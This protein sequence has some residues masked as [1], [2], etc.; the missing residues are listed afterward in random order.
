MQPP[1]QV[2]FLH[3]SLPPASTIHILLWRHIIW[4][5]GLVWTLGIYQ[6]VMCGG[7]ADIRDL[8]CFWCDAWVIANQSCHCP[9]Q[10]SPLEQAISASHGWV[11]PWSWL[12]QIQCHTAM[13]TEW[14]RSVH[15]SWA[16]TWSKVIV[17]QSSLPT[18]SR[19][20]QCPGAPHEKSLDFPEPSVSTMVLQL[21]NGTCLP[22]VWSQ[23]YGA[24]SVTL[25]AYSPGWVFT[26]VISLSL[27]VPS[28]GHKSLPDW[29][30]FLFTRLHVYLSYSLGCMEILLS[31]S[32]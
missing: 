16:G 3:H 20:S 28:Q 5:M 24:K 31:V 6:V 30:S 29:F 13:W 11:F 9:T 14:G 10:A 27:W 17:E 23:D 19:A 22:F 7:V 2:L 18:T 1:V 12:P 25:T 32:S 21:A 15:S 4:Q 8:A 26:C